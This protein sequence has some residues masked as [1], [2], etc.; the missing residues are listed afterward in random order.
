MF[1]RL[2]ARLH[3]NMFCKDIHARHVNEYD[4]YKDSFRNMHLC[5]KLA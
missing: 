3:I 1:Q 5:T 4:I 2:E